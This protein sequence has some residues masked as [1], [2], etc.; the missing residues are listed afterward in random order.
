VP[1]GNGHA[2]AYLEKHSGLQIGNRGGKPPKK[3]IKVRGDIE[4]PKVT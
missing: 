4:A 1:Q 3:T 2:N